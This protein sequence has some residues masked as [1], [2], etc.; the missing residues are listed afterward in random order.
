VRPDEW[1]ISL[2]PAKE[3][4]AFYFVD[5]C[6]KPDLLADLAHRKL[7]WAVID[8]HI[9]AKQ[10][11]DRYKESFPQSDFSNYHY[12]PDACG[13]TAVWDHFFKNKE[14]P[15]VL[16]FIEINDT[17]TWDR[18]KNSRYVDQYIKTACKRGVLADYEHLLDTFDYGE[19][20]D[21]GMLLYKRLMNDVEFMCQKAVELDFDGTPVLCVNTPH[22]VDHVG[23]HLAR[24]AKNGLGLSYYIL[25]GEDHVKFSIRG[26]SGN[27]ARLLAQKYGGGGHDKSSGFTMKISEFVELLKRNKK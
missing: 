25:P 10:E 21:K 24:I 1:N 19:A 22:N 15:E 9:T 8:H 26:V 18:D 11:I 13:A 4:D 17:W 27:N 3:G 14:R 5:V 6:P 16:T 20:V 2:T 12:Y 7:K 23:N